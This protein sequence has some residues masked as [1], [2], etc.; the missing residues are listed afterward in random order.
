MPSQQ[1]D[2]ENLIGGEFVAGSGPDGP[3][4]PLVGEDARLVVHPEPV[5]LLASLPQVFGLVQELLRPDPRLA[6]VLVEQQAAGVREDGDQGHQPEEQFP[7]H[8]AHPFRPT[9]RAV[10]PARGR[11]D[12]GSL[13]T[14]TIG[15]AGP[16]T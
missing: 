12:R 14:D 10:R 13:S 3:V 1:A 4:Q 5:P 7:P 2:C 6:V 11:A 8:L 15:T 9:P 16:P